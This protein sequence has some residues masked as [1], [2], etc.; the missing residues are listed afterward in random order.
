MVVSGDQLLE[1]ATGAELHLHE[2]L[3]LRTQPRT[4]QTHT[5]RHTDTANEQG[6]EAESELAQAGRG[7]GDGEAKKLAV[8]QASGERRL[9]GPRT[10]SCQAHS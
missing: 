4:A 1:V 2:E 8:I 6:A 7:D 9:A 3:A 10:S 5:N